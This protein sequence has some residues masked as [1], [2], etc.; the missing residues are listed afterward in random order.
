MGDVKGSGVSDRE[1]VDDSSSTERPDG[2]QGRSE[3]S[4]NSNDEEPSKSFQRAGRHA[5]NPGSC[6]N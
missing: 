1:R 3:N 5:G 6:C 4:G 2:L